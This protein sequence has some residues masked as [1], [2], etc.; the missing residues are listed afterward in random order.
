MS[1]P[2]V[3]VIVPN[4]NYRRFLPERLES[5]FNQTFR[6]FEVILL[7][8]C[9]T[10][11]SRSLIESYR[12]NPH[13]AEI[14]YNETNSGSPF[15]QWEKGLTLARG[16]YVWI[17][18][19]DDCASPTLLEECVKALE[20]PHDVVLA[21]VMSRSIDAHSA[22]L[23]QCRY[24][25]C[26]ADGNTHIYIG[27]DFILNKMS[28]SNRCYNASMTV[29]RR[30]AWQSISVKDYMSMRYCGDWLFWLYIMRQGNVAVVQENLSMFRTHGN[31]TMDSARPN[32]AFTPEVWKIFHYNLTNY[33]DIPA[34]T[35]NQM[36][37][38]MLRIYKRPK[39]HHLLPV[40][41]VMSPDFD[42]FIAERLP[43]YPLYWLYKHLLLP[44]HRPLANRP[45]RSIATISPR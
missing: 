23:G 9:S 40:K 26:P 19:A 43:R 14:V 35:A 10:D 32:Q 38:N 8:D 31:S 27:R 3:S 4:Y 7:D 6:N 18:E 16:K 5:I 36:I 28:Q 17:A 39:S 41:G 24:D 22:D 12:S 34:P 45:L 33:P 25:D 11:D 29:F 20:S 15:V 21:M 42:R 44:L 13:V 37:Y 1:T 30:S 2:L